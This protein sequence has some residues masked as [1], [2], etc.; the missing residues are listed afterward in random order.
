MGA[1]KIC[2]CASIINLGQKQGN[3]EILTIH[4]IFFIN[5]FYWQYSTPKE[6]KLVYQF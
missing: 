2:T 3:N 1:P 6:R 4:I 5:M